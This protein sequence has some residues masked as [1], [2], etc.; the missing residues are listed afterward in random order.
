[1]KEF[2]AQLAG[3]FAKFPHLPAGAREFIVKVSPWLA[4]IFLIA[5]LPFILIALGL[6]TIAAPFAFLNGVGSGASYGIGLIFTI[7]S[8]ILWA[9]SIPGLFKR[10]RSGWEFSFYGVLLNFVQGLVAVNI[11]SAIIGAVIGLYILFEVKE[12]YH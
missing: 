6:G 5:L 9:L 3:W 7:A 10:H 11:L 12:Y 1:M 2:E 8:I 4:V